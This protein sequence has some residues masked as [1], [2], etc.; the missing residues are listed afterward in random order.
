MDEYYS[1]YSDYSS[2]SEDEIDPPEVFCE[3]ELDYWDIEDLVSHQPPPPVIEYMK[4]IGVFHMRECVVLPLITD[5]SNVMDPICVNN[6]H[7]F[8]THGRENKEAR[9][10]F[11]D[12]EVIGEYCMQLCEICSAD[13]SPTLLRSC[14]LRVIGHGRFR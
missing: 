11:E 9:L 12:F 6:W 14:M 7:A 3:R 5:A 8:W 1:D 2:E 10:T 4:P 13:V